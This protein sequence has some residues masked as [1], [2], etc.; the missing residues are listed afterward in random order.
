MEYT[1]SDIC[2]VFHYLFLN[3]TCWNAKTHTLCRF[4]N[5]LQEVRNDSIGFS[6]FERCDLSIYEQDNSKW[7]KERNL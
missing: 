3:T 1:Q 7:L 2:E 4:G 5:L 6:L